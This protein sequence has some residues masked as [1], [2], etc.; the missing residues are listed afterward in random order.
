[1]KGFVKDAILKGGES[2]IRQAW[3]GIP[4]ILDHCGK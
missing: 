2:V 1:M 4:D 3:V